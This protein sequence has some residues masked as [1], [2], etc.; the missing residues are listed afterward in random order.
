MYTFFKHVTLILFWNKIGKFMQNP[1]NLPGSESMS[2]DI[3]LLQY[4]YE[5]R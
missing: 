2:S 1:Q 4:L 5:F 3:Y